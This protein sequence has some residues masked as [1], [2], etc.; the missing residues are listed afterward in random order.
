MF[1][2][3]VIKQAIEQKVSVAKCW[4]NQERLSGL[5]VTGHLQRGMTRDPAPWVKNVVWRARGHEKYGESGFYY[6]GGEPWKSTDHL[7]YGA[8][9][10]CVLY[11]M[12]KKFH[13][14][15]SLLFLVNLDFKLLY[16][17]H[18]LGSSGSISSALSGFSNDDQ[19]RKKNKRKEKAK[20]FTSKN[21]W[22]H[23]LV[24][25]KYCNSFLLQKVP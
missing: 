18:K 20:N 2:R 3:K 9:H 10:A 15:C 16:I 14:L 1:E 8:I 25:Y 24:Q 19:T 5:L 23:L 22:A 7:K 13:I 21:L 11:S 12:V 6:N 17:L 4:H